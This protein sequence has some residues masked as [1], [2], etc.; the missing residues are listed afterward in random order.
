M[1]EHPGGTTARARQPYVQGNPKR[2]VSI[3]LALGLLLQAFSAIALPCVHGGAADPSPGIWC[4]HDLDGTPDSD[5]ENPFAC[6]KC[7]L[8]STL[9]VFAAP[10]LPAQTAGLHRPAIPAA[11]AAERIRSFIPDQPSR[12]PIRPSA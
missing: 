5:Q 10:A 7:A 12:P 2:L 1:S 8:A 11:T 4:A 9:S 3:L 6:A